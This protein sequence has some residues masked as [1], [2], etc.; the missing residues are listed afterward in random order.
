MKDKILFILHLPE[1][2]HGSSV[3]GKQIHDSSKINEVFDCRFINLSTSDNI[4]NI[5]S[6]SFSK[7]YK[8]I[9]ILVKVFVAL[10]FT[11]VKKV[12]IAPTVS[13]GGFY[14][15]YLIILILKLFKKKRIYHLHN[16]GVGKRQKNLL[17]NILYKSFFKNAK[18]ILLS[19]KLYYDVSEFVDKKDVY[20]CPNGIKDEFSTNKNP[21]NRNKQIQIL[22]LSNLI[23]SKGVYVLLDACKMLLDKKIDFYC[24]FVGGEG[25]ISSQCFNKKILELS[26]ENNVTY[27]GKKYNSDKREVFINSDVFVFPTFYH[28]ETFGLVNVEAMMYHLP[29]ISTD[30]GAITDIVINDQNG[31]IIEKENSDMLFEKLELL[32]HNE[33]LRIDMGNH[34]R[35][36][37]EEKF[38][39]K[40]FESQLLS[41]LKRF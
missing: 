31:Y 6:V 20:I 29:I 5:G 27:L 21:S 41:V 7:I 40:V 36:R 26:L 10:A 8:Y 38:S 11:N 3:V 17:S 9:N 37:F 19:E 14:K 4:S 28:N 25:D 39:L 32:I 1:P 2:I 22:F 18:I 13:R 35:K 30:E 16:K 15:D 33:K 24:R 23:E 34:G 12:Y